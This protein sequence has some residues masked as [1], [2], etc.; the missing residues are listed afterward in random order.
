MPELFSVILE[1]DDAML[2]HRKLSLS[3]PHQETIDNMVPKISD[4]KNSTA[5]DDS[6]DD[7]P[8]SAEET[9]L[10]GPE[11]KHSSID[12]RTNLEYGSL[13]VK[14]DEDETFLSIASQVCLPFFI[15]GLG[16][17]GAGML[18][19]VVQHWEVFMS[20]PELFIMVPS[21]LGLKGN[22]EMTL[23]SR[24]STH[25]HLGNLDSRRDR[26]EMSFANLALIQCQAIV[27]GLLSALAAVIMGWI[28]DGEFS[29][30]HALFLGASA[31]LTASL[32]SFI[33]GVVMI[34][35]VIISRDCGINPDNIATPIAASLGDLTT[36]TLLAG[37]TSFLYKGNFLYLKLCFLYEKKKK[38]I[39]FSHYSQVHFHTSS[40][41]S[42][43]KN[44]C[45]TERWWY[46]SPTTIGILLL[47]IPLW[48]YIAGRNPHTKVVLQTGWTPVIS[49]MVISSAGG[50]ILEAALG[51]YR[52][53]AV[54]Q[55]VIN[56]AGGNL[57]AVQASRL[58]TF[59]HRNFQLGQ[60]PAHL[61]QCCFNPLHIYFGRGVHAKTVRVLLLFVIPGHLAFAFTIALVKA[62]HTTVTPMFIVFY[63][64]AAFIQVA[65]L[66]FIGH[67]L[68]HAMWRAAI[69][70]DNSAIPY[71]TALGDLL[72]T[73]LLAVAFHV[74]YLLGDRDSDVGD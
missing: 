7:S 37:V 52:G 68:L 67:L 23:A 43:L 66:L 35:V 62:G 12:M 65:L 53:I 1:S 34:L 15:A 13:I 25:A 28:P 48:V 3:A 16:M 72:G 60:L 21:L 59:F 26:L 6:M 45:S 64:L 58:S 39:L 57:V 49:A 17:V 40:I 69:D 20:V 8:M 27:V 30:S 71:L 2:R 4:S 47:S 11:M 55:P 41:L 54:F 9:P 51:S 29:L 22:L 14:D 10:V 38:K 61:Q 33:L 73:G 5:E 36:L 56:G 74:L 42:T 31:L 50:L 63:L 24:L 32:A 70:P 46:L 44:L 18:L 19:D